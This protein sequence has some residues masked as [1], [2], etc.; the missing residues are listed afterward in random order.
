MFILNKEYQLQDLTTK[1]IS[2]E[3]KENLLIESSKASKISAL[4][5]SISEL[6][7]FK[8]SRSVEQ[9]KS[10]EEKN[11][12]SINIQKF[13]EEYRKIK[14]KLVFLEGSLQNKCSNRKNVL[15][16]AK[17]EG[18][19]LSF[20]SKDSNTMGEF[21]SSPTYDLIEDIISKVI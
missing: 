19:E 16:N 6:H 10:L 14:R 5:K 7:D 18:I 2:I 8:V 20:N 15:K 13:N 12:I 11:Q 4:E 9:N 3:A 17:I 21:E 1:L